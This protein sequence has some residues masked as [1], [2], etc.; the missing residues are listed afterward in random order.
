[1][2]A[3]NYFSHKHTRSH[4]YTRCEGAL[5]NTTRWDVQT[6]KCS[7]QWW[8]KMCGRWKVIED[9]R[10]AGLYVDLIV[11]TSQMAALLPWLLWWCGVWLVVRPELSS[12]N[13]M[14]FYVFNVPTVNILRW[15]PRVT[16]ETSCDPSCVKLE[17]SCSA[18]PHFPLQP[19]W[20]LSHSSAAQR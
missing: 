10:E 13:L 9:N 20:L 7:R 5:T 2:Q 17:N 6:Q 16:A 11:A 15:A 3:I 19:Q 18:T 8:E 1:M 4:V 14:C 12:L